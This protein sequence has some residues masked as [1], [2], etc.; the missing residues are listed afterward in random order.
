MPQDVLWHSSN[1]ALASDNELTAIRPTSTRSEK[2]EGDEANRY[3][4]LNNSPEILGIAEMSNRKTHSPLF[5]LGSS[6]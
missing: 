1:S 2:R 3:L 4:N 6:S 5:L